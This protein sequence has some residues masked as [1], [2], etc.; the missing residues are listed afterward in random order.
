M[1]FV[2][3]S[4]PS[5]AAFVL[6][7][8]KQSILSP[9]SIYSLQLSNPLAYMPSEMS[10]LFLPRWAFIFFEQRHVFVSFVYLHIELQY[11]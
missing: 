5:I 6:L 7:P 1:Y 2:Q 10:A 8:S 4:C 11:L 9:L 3:L